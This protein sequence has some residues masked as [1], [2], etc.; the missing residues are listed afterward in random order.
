MNRR[1]MSPMVVMLLLSAPIAAG[2]PLA[3]AVGPGRIALGLAAPAGLAFALL[4]PVI[5]WLHRRRRRRPPR[6]IVPS[7]TPWLALLADVPPARRRVPPTLL[8]LLHLT[9]AGA[10]ALAMA[11]PRLPGPKGQGGA[12]VLILD[13]STSMRAADRW[14]EAADQARARIARAA[15]PVTVVTASDR[16]RV[17]ALRETDRR[18]LEAALSGLEPGSVGARWDEA[19]A[20]AR[21]AGGGD[22]AVVAVTDGGDARP[23]QGTTGVGWVLVGR[24][25][26]NRAV[27]DVSVRRTA[28]GTEVFAR[29]ANLDDRPADVDLALRLDA[30]AV[31]ARAVHLAPGASQDFNWSLPVEAS[32]AEIRIAGNDRQPADDVAMVPLSAP[33]VRLQLVGDSPAAARALAAVPGARVVP[34]GLGTLRFDGSV[35]A[36]VFVGEAPAILPPGGAMLFAPSGAGLAALQPGGPAPTPPAVAG[37][38][39]GV[40]EG[41][42]TTGDHPVVWGLDLAGVDLGSG[43]A[44]DVPSWAEP[45]LRLDGRVVGYAGDR[46]GRRMVVFAFRP[47]DGNLASHLAFP[48]LVARAVGWLS[49]PGWP[50]VVPAG[51]RVPVPGVPCWIVTPDGRRSRVAGAFDGTFR[52]GLY[53]LQVGTDPSSERVFAVVSGDADES[54]LRQARPAGDGEAV[55]TAVPTA[56]R[57]MWPLLVV[58]ALAAIAAEMVCRHRPRR[59]GRAAPPP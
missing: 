8:L 5:W 32:A 12:L 45:I 4:L 20:L 29:V 19:L 50:T 58:A 35:D 7:I 36:S 37:A 54:D 23:E 55:G 2:V 28:D 17:I 1:P 21:A 14:A 30:R 24:P 31:D 47:D 59:A 40:P 42:L 6:R 18:R 51:R 57:P 43:A 16:P 56:G 11:D 46:A 13:T 49:E 39:L 22:A 52:E 15:G 27:T 41:A 25:E 10:L 26:P 9:V 3:Q 44:L 33:E 53:R 48:L 34:A 38:V